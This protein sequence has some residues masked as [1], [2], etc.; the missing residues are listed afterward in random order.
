LK[1][2]KTQGIPNTIG[3]NI[4]ARRGSVKPK[5]GFKAKA[6]LGDVVLFKKSSN[7]CG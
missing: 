3:Q 4:K 6:T 2:L 1:N 7:G 5:K